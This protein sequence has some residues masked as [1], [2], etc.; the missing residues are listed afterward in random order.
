MS[1]EYTGRNTKQAVCR[2]CGAVVNAGEGCQYEMWGYPWDGSDTEGSV[3]QLLDSWVTCGDFGPCH[4]RTIEQGTNVEALRRIVKTT[5]PQWAKRAEKALSE[6]VRIRQQQ[7]VAADLAARE[8]GW[9]TIGG[10]R[11]SRG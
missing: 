4:D 2:D 10:P 6:I 11:P 8:A 9:G 7:A 5:L 3:S 1:T